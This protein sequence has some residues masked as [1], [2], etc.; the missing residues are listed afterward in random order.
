MKLELYPHPPSGT[1]RGIHLWPVPNHPTGAA[2]AEWVSR[3]RRC[4]F[5]WAVLLDGGSVGSDGRTSSQE[6]CEA[7]LAEGIIPIVRLYRGEPNPGRL[8]E[9]NLAAVRALVKTGVRYFQDNCEP[10]LSNEWKP[11]EWKAGGRPERVMSDWI[12]NAMAICRQ[13]GIPL[14][15]PLAPCGWHKESGSIP[16]NT[17]AV[18]W[19][20]KNRAADMATLIIEGMGLATHDYALNHWYRD[21]KG[22]WHFEYPDDP[23]A[24]AREP[25]VTVMNYDNGVTGWRALDRLF[26]EAFGQ[27]VPI[28]GTEGGIPPKGAWYQEDAGYPGYGEKE[29]AEG[30][31]AMYD[32]IERNTPAHYFTLASW[33]FV[34]KDAGGHDP[35]WEEQSWYQLGKELPVVAAMHVN[36]TPKPEPPG[37][38]APLAD[39]VISRA[40]VS[41]S[42][43]LRGVARN[44]GAALYKKAQEKRLGAPMGSEMEA[45][46]KD[47]DHKIVWQ[48][49]AMGIVWCFE[50][51]WGNVRVIEW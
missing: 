23:K 39:D 4:H 35:T 15:P 24:Q 16:W 12:E 32:W 34:N 31:V 40:I 38:P 3:V 2:L 8:D 10:N 28:L 20:K 18:A 48:S 22:V 47:S 43:V 19:L 42:W 6:T 51:D 44:Q 5:G 27:H 36:P 17:T 9:G 30:T 29:Q 45:T 7:L 21:E 41:E 25:G 26:F 11:G 33:I 50:G 13:G 37:A 46:L 14:Y 49:Y 1:K